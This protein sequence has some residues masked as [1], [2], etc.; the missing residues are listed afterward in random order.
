MGHQGAVRRSLASVAH[1]RALLRLESAYGLY[2]VYEMGLWVAVLLW[3]YRVGGASFAGAASVVMLVPAAALAPVGGTIAGRLARDTTLRLEYLAHTLLMGVLTVLLAADASRWLVV[4]V[5]M[6]WCIL[7]AWTRPAH[8]AA[9]AELSSTPAD[10][11]AANSVSGT[12]QSAG[13][14]AGPVIAGFTAGI[15]GPQVAAA[16]FTAMGLTCVLLLIGV[17]LGQPVGASTPAPTARAGPFTAELVR[18]PAVAFVLLVVGVEFVV[19]GCLQ[20]LAISFVS[21][22]LGDGPTAA[23]LLIGAQGLGG[24]IGAATAIVLVRWHNLSYP[25][26]ASLVACGLPLVLLPAVDQLLPAIAVLVVVGAAMA[27]FGVAGI[28][29]LQRSVPESLMTGIVGL[30][31]SAFVGG[32][33]IG[34]ALTPWLVRHFGAAGGYAALGVA[35]V[36]LA[37]VLVPA[38][39]RLDTFATF[40]PKVVEL[41]QGIPF[42]SVLDVAALERLAHGAV[43]ERIP[44]GQDVFRQGDH[45]TAY[46]LVESGELDVSIDGQRLQHLLGAGDGFGE[47]ALLRD[48]PRTT[49]IRTTADSLL[50]RVDRELFLATVAGS[51]GHDVAERHI[52]R[53][54]KGLR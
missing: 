10:A 32:F 33:A 48:V 8:Y 40:R 28:T 11:A 5:A 43:V 35:L 54:L 14:F 52:D 7:V 3:A 30:R 42:L 22:H 17:Q 18:R 41:L 39:R 51:S 6:T 46:F 15:G 45:G 9:A 37:L 50:W 20:L 38:V 27:F 23:G 2:T 25:V 34:S 24:I 47:I 4:G 31:E 12:L 21:Q 44:A 53:Q 29:L 19:E 13:Y 1:N 49:T 26:A 16:V 36:A